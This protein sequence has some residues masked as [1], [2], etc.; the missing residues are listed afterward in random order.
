L[1]LLDK[2]LIDF[3]I[4][5]Q[6]TTQQAG[7][8]TRPKSNTQMQITQV[9]SK[10]ATLHDYQIVLGGPQS[11]CEQPMRLVRVRFVANGMPI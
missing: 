3:A 7:F 10:T 11:R 4:F 9:L 8:I 6:L 2:G 1:L 5:D